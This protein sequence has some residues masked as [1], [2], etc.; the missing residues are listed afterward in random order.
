MCDLSTVLLFGL[1]PCHDWMQ[2]VVLPLLTLGLIVAIV[3]YLFI[4]IREKIEV[5][6][7]WWNARWRKE[8]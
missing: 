3:V 4:A 5:V 7:K 6:R 8:P 2:Y 1:Q